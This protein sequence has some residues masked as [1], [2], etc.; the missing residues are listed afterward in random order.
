MRY[1]FDGCRLLEYQIDISNFNINNV[2][3]IWGMFGGCGDG[4]KSK[5]K[6]QLNN[7]KDEAFHY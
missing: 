2:K 3:D 1:M 5:I 7:I 6:S 4:T